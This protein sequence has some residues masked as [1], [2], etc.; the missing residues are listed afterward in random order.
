MKNK[1]TH[2]PEEAAGIAPPAAVTRR[3]FIKRMGPPGP[4]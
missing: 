1:T 4:D 2:R 3:D